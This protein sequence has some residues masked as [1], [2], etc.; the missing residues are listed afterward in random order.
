MREASLLVERLNTL[1]VSNARKRFRIGS[2]DSAEV[3]ES[4][5]G[6]TYLDKE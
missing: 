1:R 2:A 3:N 4:L 5:G 6:V